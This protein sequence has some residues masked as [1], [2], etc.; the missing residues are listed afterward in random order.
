MHCDNNLNEKYRAVFGPKLFGPH[1]DP[2]CRGTTV[3]YKS[4]I[5]FFQT[6]KSLRVKYMSL[7]ER[8]VGFWFSNRRPVQLEV[9]GYPVKLR[10]YVIV[11]YYEIGCATLATT[12]PIIISATRLVCKCFISW[13]LHI[14]PSEAR[15]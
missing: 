15:Y 2:N 11:P 9:T 14:S 5:C 10:V 7:E 6:L 12:C 1:G 3:S 4:M 13:L 8:W